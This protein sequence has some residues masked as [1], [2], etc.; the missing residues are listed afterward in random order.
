M[1]LYKNNYYV[2]IFLTICLTYIFIQFI[3]SLY[4]FYK[5]K[6]SNIL[7][8]IIICNIIGFIGIITSLLNI[9]LDINCI[10]WKIVS[11]SSVFYCNTLAASF[12]I[13]KIKICYSKKYTIYFYL[14]II[15][16]Q[17]I[18]ISFIFLNLFIPQPV[19]KI[20]EMCIIEV[21]SY[22]PF[23]KVIIDITTNTI[24][25]LWFIFIIYNNYK[26][27][28]NNFF[29][30]LIKDGSLFCIILA[31]SN[32]IIGF[33]VKYEVLGIYSVYLYSL[34]LMLISGLLTN[35]IKN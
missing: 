13:L 30:A 2:I 9:I 20:N 28:S 31:L 1:D 35:Q 21:N 18:Y 16:I 27:S 5:N 3:S 4:K 24:F 8:I 34:D 22:L 6:K 7:L 33:L 23:S 11:I 26:K 15:L 14:G 32:I 12:L 19:S 29:R 17:L 10:Y 25:S